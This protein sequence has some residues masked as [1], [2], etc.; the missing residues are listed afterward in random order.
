MK[1]LSLIALAVV[2]LALGISYSAQQATFKRTIV[3][4]ADISAPGRE[5]VTAL[6]EFQPAGSP[7]AHTHFGEE[8]GYVIDGT[9]VVEQDGKAPMTVTAGK[10]FVIPAGV[11]HNAKNTGTGPARVL[12]TYVVEKGKPLATPVQG[13][14]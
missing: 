10:A 11:V 8:I 1:R 3:A 9:V 7:G 4:Q 13:K 12:A 5:V 2:T 6:V 14:E